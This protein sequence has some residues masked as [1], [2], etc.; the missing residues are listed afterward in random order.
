M[1]TDTFPNQEC[2]SNFDVSFQNSDSYHCSVSDTDSDYVYC[3]TPGPE[4]SIAAYIQQTKVDQE[5]TQRTLKLRYELAFPGSAPRDT[6]GS[7]VLSEPQ[8][9]NFTVAAQE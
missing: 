2:T 5:D 3:L 1:C 6:F 7:K 8:D 4:V 9:P